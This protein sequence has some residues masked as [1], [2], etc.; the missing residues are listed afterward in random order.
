MSLQLL[1]LKVPN[2]SLLREEI[3][4]VCVVIVDYKCFGPEGQVLQDA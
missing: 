1:H 3:N 4:L 2:T